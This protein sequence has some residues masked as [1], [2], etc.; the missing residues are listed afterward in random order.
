MGILINNAGGDIWLRISINSD[1]NAIIIWLTSEE[2]LMPNIHNEIEQ[3][4]TQY[5]KGK[6][7]RVVTFTSGRND[8]I[9]NTKSLLS[10][11]IK[12]KS[13]STN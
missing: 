2:S 9:E 6:K 1:V 10:H 4:S 13:S 5:T 11:N 12:R 3:L 8:Y 7:Y